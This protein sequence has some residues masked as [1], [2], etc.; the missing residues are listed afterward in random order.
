MGDV[1]RVEMFLADAGR[2]HAR[3]GV[4]VDAGAVL[5]E[6][7][8]L[9]RLETG[10]RGVVVL[11]GESLGCTHGKNPSLGCVGPEKSPDGDGS[12]SGLQDHRTGAALPRLCL[13]SQ[14][15][16]AISSFITSFEPP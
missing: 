4:E 10:K 8:A 2:H 13:W 15:V 6:A 9:H 3:L 16:R 12:P 1:Q 11:H 5:D 14:K 7:L